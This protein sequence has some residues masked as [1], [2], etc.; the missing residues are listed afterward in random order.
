VAGAQLLAAGKEVVYRIRVRMLNRLSRIA[1]SQFETVGAG[2]VT[3]HFV[4]DLNAI[5]SFLGATVSGLVVSVLTLVGV[6]AV[7]FWMHWQLALFILL[8]NPVV[9]LFSTKAR[10]AGEG[11][12]KFENRAFEVF[13]DALA[14]TLDALT[15]IRAMNR[16]KHY[17][18]R[19]T[20]RPTT[21][22][23]MPRRT[24]GS[25]TR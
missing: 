10:Q 11:L 25:P 1:L 4:T 9:I 3:S 24:P 23:S 15:Q 22:A 17:L 14:E 12:K 19:V 13:Q 16:E 6:A 2:R 18:A 8:L 5:D 7:L 21:S 20:E